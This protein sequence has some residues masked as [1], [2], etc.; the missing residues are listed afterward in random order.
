M[1]CHGAS[2]DS[3]PAPGG[4]VLNAPASV[5]GDATPSKEAASQGPPTQMTLVPDNYKEAADGLDDAPSIQRAVDAACAGN[6]KTLAFHARRYQI[7]SPVTQN[8]SANWQGQGYEEQAG[9]NYA[10]PGTWFDIGAGFSGKLAS[11]ITIAAGAGSTFENFGVAEPSQPPP[12]IANYDPSFPADSAK[13]RIVGYAP[14]RWSP[15]PFYFVFSVTGSPGNLF[16]HIM[17]DGVNQGFRV[18][19]SGRTSFEDIR[20]QVFNT[21][22]DIHES[23]DVSRIT[24]VHN[25]PYWSLADPVMA[26]DQENAYVIASYRNDTPFWE[27]IFGFGVRAVLYLADDPD[28]TTTGIQAGKVSCDYTV[29]CIQTD[30]RSPVQVTGQFGSI[31][32]FGPMW[33]TTYPASLVQYPGSSM[34]QLDSSAVLQIG[35][36]ENFGT[37]VATMS[38]NAPKQPSNLMIGSLF[39]HANMMSPHSF[40]ARFPTVSATIPS[41]VTISMVPAIAGATAGFRNTNTGSNGPGIGVYQYGAATPIH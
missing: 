9:A 28:G 4:P 39:V 21:M 3:R 30:T 11:P 32:T 13:L 38:L 16:R 37:D 18:D 14:G 7:N 34:L 29:Y 26:Y 2:A 27:N 22:F 17:L 20:G 12:P 31:R 25:W 36:M 19:H 5:N 6:V 15:A 23:Y 40:V 35:S 33:S 41:L 1:M 10:A 24:D 8:C